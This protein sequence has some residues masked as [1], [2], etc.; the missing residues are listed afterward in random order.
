MKWIFPGL[1]NDSKLSL[2]LTEADVIKF[3]KKI[4]VLLTLIVLHYFSP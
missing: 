1:I 4:G 3:N 2:T